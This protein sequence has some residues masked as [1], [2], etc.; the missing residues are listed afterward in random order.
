[1]RTPTRARLMCALGL[2]GRHR[3][4]GRSPRSPP[5]TAARTAIY[6]FIE[7]WYN[8]R[9]L[10]S[11][12]GYGGTGGVASGLP[13][14]STCDLSLFRFDGHRWRGG[15]AARVPVNVADALT[16]FLIA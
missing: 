16:Q 14:M 11:S 6:E 8:L 12:L 9:R 7:S 1:M 10:H 5:R 15:Q 13:S 4:R 2:Q 3:R